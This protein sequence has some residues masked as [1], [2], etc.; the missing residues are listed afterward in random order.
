MPQQGKRPVENHVESVNNLFRGEYYFRDSVNRLPPRSVIIWEEETMA[1]QSKKTARALRRLEET[2]KKYAV[3]GEDDLA[4]DLSKEPARWDRL[5]RELGRKAAYRA[6]GSFLCRE[7]RLKNGRSFRFSDRCVA[8]ELGWHLD[9]YLRVKG[10]CG[11]PVHMTSLVFTKA[12][13][14]RHSQRVEIEE[15]DLEK[16]WK[17]RVVFRYRRG[18]RE[19]QA[20]LAWEAADRI[21]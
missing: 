21:R 6:L 1:D 16:N 13:L 11:Y 5:I 3:I 10:F 19:R 4:L 2:A 14:E 15:K 18:E 17:Q 7:F 9:V 8:D 20:E 12:S